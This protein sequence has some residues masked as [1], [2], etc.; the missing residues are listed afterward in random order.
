M[1]CCHT[2]KPQ[3]VEHVRD[4]CYRPHSVMLGGVPNKNIV[5]NVLRLPNSS[6]IYQERK[7]FMTHSYEPQLAHSHRQHSPI[8]AITQGFLM[9]I[10]HPEPQL[11]RCH[12][13]LQLKEFHVFNPYPE[14]QLK[15]YVL[16]HNSR[17]IPT[18]RS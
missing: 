15:G 10:R 4:N 12:S 8:R 9:L 11:K 7:S 1:R 16:S 5:Y 17:N 13:E 18:S 14:S 6:A 2:Y 3:L